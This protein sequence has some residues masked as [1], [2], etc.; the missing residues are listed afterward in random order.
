[1][2]LFCSYFIIFFS[3]PYWFYWRR[4]VTQFTHLTMYLNAWSFSKKTQSSATKHLTR[5]FSSQSFVLNVYHHT[6][7]SC[8][9][10]H[11]FKN[12]LHGLFWTPIHELAIAVDGG[13]SFGQYFNVKYDVT[14]I[15][16][17][18]RQQTLK[19]IT[20]SHTSIKYTLYIVKRRKLWLSCSCSYILT[21]NKIWMVKTLLSL[22]KLKKITVI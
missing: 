4:G 18:Y 9:A 17:V 19:E 11:L 1:M 13:N 5:L 16:G 22:K 14:W 12:T 6:K 7:F 10:G 20:V 15:P 3:F 8:I 2:F 21:S